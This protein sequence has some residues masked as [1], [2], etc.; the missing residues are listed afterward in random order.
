VIKKVSKAINSR[1]IKY[2]S[3][4]PKGSFTNGPLETVNTPSNRN[5]INRDAIS[6]FLKI[7]L[8]K[9]DKKSTY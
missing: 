4:F 2:V 7:G 8:Y 9:Q 6:S 5:N 1:E 3:A